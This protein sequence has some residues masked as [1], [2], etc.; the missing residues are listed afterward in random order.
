MN[1]QLTFASIKKPVLAA[2]P[3]PNASVPKADEKRIKPQAKDILNRLRKGTVS[4][5]ELV[6][7]A[8][9][10]NARLN[11]IR[12][13]LARI[14]MTVDCME[15]KAGNNHYRIVPLHGSKYQK[16]LMERQKRV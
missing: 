5:K 12:K 16:K 15:G 2:G 7:V 8:R 9:Q 6:S 10:Y 11:E 4:T 3:K 13:H 1:E 14:G